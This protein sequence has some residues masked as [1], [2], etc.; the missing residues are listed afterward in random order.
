MTIEF[1]EHHNKGVEGRAGGLHVTGGDDERP[2]I[3]PV[4]QSVRNAADGE[5]RGP[6]VGPVGRSGVT[7]TAI[8]ARSSICRP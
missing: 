2:A 4:A 7:R 3:Q 6:F 8:P 1:R 5:H